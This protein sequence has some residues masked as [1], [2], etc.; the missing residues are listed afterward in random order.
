MKSVAFVNIIS[1]YVSNSG[2]KATSVI[3][4]SGIYVSIHLR[5]LDQGRDDLFPAF[6][7]LI[8]GGV[9]IYYSLHSEIL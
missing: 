2:N 6:F 4:V 8:F 5:E 9:P 3:S 7:T 1:I